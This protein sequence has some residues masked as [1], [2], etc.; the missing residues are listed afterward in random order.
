MKARDKHLHKEV[1]TARQEAHC[2]IFSVSMQGSD[3]NHGSEMARPPTA[4]TIPTITN[5][6]DLEVYER[7]ETKQN[8]KSLLKCWALG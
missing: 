3:R 2:F 8:I 1:S 4:W 6:L 5:L 7:L